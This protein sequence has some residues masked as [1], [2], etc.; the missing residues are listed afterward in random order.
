MAKNTQNIYW[1]KA[2]D[3]CS[4]SNENNIN[5]TAIIETI[6]QIIKEDENYLF[7][8]SLITYDAH[9]E[10]CSCHLEKNTDSIELHKIVKGAIIEKIEYNK[11]K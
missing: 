9:Q 10:N 5:C 3:H 1:I 6:G 7:V 2:W 4:T 11:S 8:R